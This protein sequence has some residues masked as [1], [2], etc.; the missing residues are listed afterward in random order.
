MRMGAQG[1][2]GKCTRSKPITVSKIARLAK[3]SQY[4]SFRLRVG[5]AMPEIMRFLCYQALIYAK[6]AL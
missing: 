5:R 2:F 1:V 3:R 6:A 4:R